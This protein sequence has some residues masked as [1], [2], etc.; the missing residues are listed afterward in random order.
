[1][2]MKKLTIEEKAKRYDEAFNVALETYQTQPMYK[3]WLEKMFP[4]LKESEN[5]RIMGNIIDTIHLYYGE[6]LEDEAKEMV[7]K[8]PVEMIERAV[9]G[10]LPKTRLGRQMYKK[11]FVYA[12]AEHPHT[13]QQPEVMEVK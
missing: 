8:Y 2:N 1:M 9:K 13:A 12:G 4:A 7:E 11:L 10:M 6:P 3:N 5:E